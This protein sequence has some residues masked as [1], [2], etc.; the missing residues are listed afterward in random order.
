MA[1][2][3]RI[4][5]VLM[6]S[7]ASIHLVVFL[8]KK[9]WGRYEKVLITSNSMATLECTLPNHSLI[10]PARYYHP[11]Y[12]ASLLPIPTRYNKSTYYVGMC[13]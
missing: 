10:L 12:T 4:A 9:S 6:G 2:D 13:D 3:I 8:A 11:C 1:F 7:S 5:H